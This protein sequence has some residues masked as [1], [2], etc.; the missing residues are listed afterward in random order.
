MYTSR[1]RSCLIMMANER[2]PSG[3]NGVQKLGQWVE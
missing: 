1:I 2:G 3:N